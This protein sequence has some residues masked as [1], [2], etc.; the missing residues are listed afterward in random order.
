MAVF[1][2]MECSMVFENKGKDLVPLTVLLREFGSEALFPKLSVCDR[3]QRVDLECDKMVITGKLVVVPR[4]FLGRLPAL[5][6]LRFVAQD[7]LL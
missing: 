6:R 2:M 4:E 1:T 3:L 5:R 7:T